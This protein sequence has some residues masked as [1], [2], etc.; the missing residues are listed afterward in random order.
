MCVY[1]CVRACMCVTT[2]KDLSAC[3][4]LKPEKCI[5]AEPETVGMAINNIYKICLCL[6]QR[7]SS[8][9]ICL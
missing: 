8:K 5:N 9:A 2:S 7:K 6:Q 1:V 3:Q 4:I